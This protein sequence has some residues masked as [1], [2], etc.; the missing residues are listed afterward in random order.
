M[1][2]STVCAVLNFVGAGWPLWRHSIDSCFH[3]RNDAPSFRLLWQCCA[4]I[5]RLHVYIAKIIFGKCPSASLLDPQWTFWE[6][7]A[8][9]VWCPRSAIIA[10]TRAREAADLF[11]VAC[12]DTLWFLLTSHQHDFGEPRLLLFVVSRYAACHSG[13]YGRGL[14]RGHVCSTTSNSTDVCTVIA[15]DSHSWWMPMV[16]RFLQSRTSSLHDVYSGLTSSLYIGPFSWSVTPRPVVAELW[17]SHKSARKSDRR[18][19]V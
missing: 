12:W 6:P 5:G 7:I 2:S 19:I 3:V 9:N 17:T 1:T 14:H 10:F 4:R 15:V 18:S 13:W 8:H 16:E 11:A